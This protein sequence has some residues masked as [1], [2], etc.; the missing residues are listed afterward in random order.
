MQSLRK[1]LY[2]FSFLYDLVTYARNKAFDIKLLQQ[3]VYNIP[4]IAVGNLSTGGTGKTPMIEYLIKHFSGQNIAVISRG[5]GRKT[6]GFRIITDACASSEV[7]DE[8]LQMFLKF[9][10]DVMFA[11]GEN[12]VNAIDRVLEIAPQTDVILL[13]DAYQHRYVKASKYI[14]LTSYYKPFYKD[15][16]LPAGN[17][18]ESSRGIQRADVVVVTKCPQDLT[19]EQKQVVLKKLGLKTEQKAFF[20]TIAYSEVL[21]NSVSEIRLEDI[22]QEVTLLTGIAHPSYFVKHVSGFVNVVEHLQFSDHHH[23]SQK[24]IEK[25]ATR[26]I[27]ITTEKD[28]V[29]LRNSGLINLYYLPIKTQFLFEDFSL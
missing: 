14:L 6:K 2:P 29:R 17:L 13:D 1:L 8:P 5:Y 26:K 18:R 12:R 10:P 3:R 19:I 23:F 24:D 11:V 4:V 7:G 25:I 20:S 16:L 21:L 28:F 27:V 9:A 15:V 22:T